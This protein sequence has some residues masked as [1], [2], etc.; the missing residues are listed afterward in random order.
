[1]VVLSIPAIEKVNDDETII[2]PP[3][4]PSLID[5]MQGWLSRM[6]AKPATYVSK[7]SIVF[8][9]NRK[10]LAACAPRCG[11]V[12]IFYEDRWIFPSLS[13][14]CQDKAVNCISWSA[15]SDNILIG[16][17]DG[18][19]VWFLSP[20]DGRSC[21][22]SWMIL[23]KQPDNSSVDIIQ[24]VPSGRIV[25]T[26]CISDGRVYLWNDLAHNSVPLQQLMY[27]GAWITRNIFSSLAW[28]SSGNY[29]LAGTR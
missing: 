20:F 5:I 10:V 21:D 28:V 19:A 26:A 16:T 9:N 11:D 18:L 2:V 24:P 6:Q 23:L 7:G 22:H 13:H 17:P 14:P 4:A 29:F 27:S 3:P 15:V 1:M 12:F 8:H 25:I